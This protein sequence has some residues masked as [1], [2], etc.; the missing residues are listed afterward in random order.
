[1][2]M[3]ISLRPSEATR[4]TELAERERRDPRDQAAYLV[5]QALERDRPDSV[6]RDDQEA[7]GHSR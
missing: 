2:R 3:Y 7:V 1:M 4:L 5:A 6:S